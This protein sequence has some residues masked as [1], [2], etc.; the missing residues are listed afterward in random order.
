MSA[1]S[2]D[3]LVDRIWK[4]VN[5]GYSAQS[6]FLIVISIQRV[7]IFKYRRL[8]D[9]FA[10]PMV[11]F[12]PTI[13]TSPQNYFQIY[14]VIFLTWIC[15]LAWAFFSSTDFAQ[16]L[17]WETW[18]FLAFPMA[19][20]FILLM[21]AFIL[22]RQQQTTQAAALTIN[23]PAKQDTIKVGGKKFGKIF[24]LKFF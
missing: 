4:V 8:D 17:S 1:I 6:F 12:I 7:V 20:T 13:R 23:R 19:V 15:S 24:I 11:Q 14:G 9:L 3:L 16:T 10:R 22:Y 2:S 18:L 5:I 21:V